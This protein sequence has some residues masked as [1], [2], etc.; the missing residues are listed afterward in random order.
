VKR[1]AV[2]LGVLAFLVAGLWLVALPQSLLADLIVRS[3]G[4]TPFRVDLTN[5]S[6]GLFYNFSADG[7]TLLKADR[8]VA[9]LEDVGGRINPLALF[10]LRVSL[11][12]DGVLG[13]GDF[14]ASVGLSPGKTRVVAHADNVRMERVPFMKMI[15]LDG[16]GLLSGRADVSGGK[17]EVTF[18][19][20]DARFRPAS[21]GGITVPLD[22][23]RTA[24]GAL[25]VDGQTL[26][27][28]S[29]SL[30]GQGIYA[31]LK[32]VVTGGYLRGTMEIMPDKSFALKEVLSGTLGRYEVSP[33][34]YVV[35]IK[36]SVSF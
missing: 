29:F 20:R 8:P 3:A 16:S 9:S 19:A 5:F 11:K 22:I 6:K 30:E 18:S 36:S 1:V 34:Y 28:T 24:R 14:H 25:E 17:G 27:I 26:R 15:G 32:G 12:L 21:F 10:L 7:V 13:G 35:P 4:N 2:S 23:F 31:R 33:G